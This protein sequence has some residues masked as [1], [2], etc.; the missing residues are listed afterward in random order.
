MTRFGEDTFIEKFAFQVEAI[1]ADHDGDL[2]RDSDF[3]LDFF[4]LPPNLAFLRE[5]LAMHVDAGELQ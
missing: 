4:A 3:W 2:A 1:L 5:R